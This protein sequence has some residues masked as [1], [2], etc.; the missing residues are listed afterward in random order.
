MKL[1]QFHQPGLGK[2][3]GVVTRDEEIIDVTS[4]ETPDVL[5]LLQLANNEGIS[6]GVILAD[7]QE[8]V[9]QDDVLMF[10]PDNEGD[11]DKLKFADLDNHPDPDTLHLLMPLDPPEAWGFGVTYKRSADM[12]DKDSD[13]NIYSRVYHAERPEMFFKG[14][15]TRCTGPNGAIG[16][17]SDSTFT[18]AEPELA[19][20]LGVNGEILGYTICNDVSA[21][22]IER[23]NPLYLPQSKIFTGCCAIGPM[24]VTPSEVDDPYHLNIKC[25]IFRNGQLAYQGE[26]NTSQINWK[27]E[28]LTEFLRRDNPIPHGTVVSTGTG[29]ITP[30]D[31]PLADG[32]IVEIEIDGLGKLSNPVKQL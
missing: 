1:I 22:D 15:A 11:N 28:T 32:D 23:E 5:Q 18:A 19:Y 4:E 9:S 16:I 17:R 6:I 26:V 25:Q 31:M 7:V 14:T 20:I 10:G 13:Q 2:R 27:F 12:R 3:V 30:E 8:E 24:F 29:I 21:W